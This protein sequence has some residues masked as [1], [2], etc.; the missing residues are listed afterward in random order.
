MD[1][2]RSRTFERIR[3]PYRFAISETSDFVSKD[4]AHLL[5]GV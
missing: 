4:A 2:V 3:M 1:A 5:R